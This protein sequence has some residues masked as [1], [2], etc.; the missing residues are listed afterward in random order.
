[1][2]RRALGLGDVLHALE[3]RCKLDER[4]NVASAD[5]KQ[6][7]DF[8]GFQSVYDWVKSIVA[9]VKG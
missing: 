9:R 4:L 2:E 7:E 1:V 6:P 3:T 5:K 8:K